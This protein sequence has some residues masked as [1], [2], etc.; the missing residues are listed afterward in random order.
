MFDSRQIKNFYQAMSVGTALD[1]AVSKTISVTCNPEQAAVT[2]QVVAATGRLTGCLSQQ[3]PSL[4]DV[5]RSI[6]DK[7]AA[8]DRFLNAVGIHWPL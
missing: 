3:N 2:A 1:H 8:A 5:M 4:K 6:D 7:N